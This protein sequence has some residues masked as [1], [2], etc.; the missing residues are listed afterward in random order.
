MSFQTVCSQFSKIS[1]LKYV[2][3]KD[4]ENIGLFSE[5]ETI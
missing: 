1:V 5:K 3:Y 4:E 2:C